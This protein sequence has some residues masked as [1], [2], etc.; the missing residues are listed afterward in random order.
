MMLFAAIL[1]CLLVAIGLYYMCFMN[2]I[3][4]CTAGKK[5]ALWGQMLTP[6][7]KIE[8]LRLLSN[9]SMPLF[10]VGWIGFF[11][12]KFMDSYPYQIPNSLY[13]LFFANHIIPPVIAFAVT[14][15]ARKLQ[16]I[17]EKAN[18]ALPL[19]N[20]EILQ[21]VD[22]TAPQANAIAL[23]A[24]KICLL[25]KSSFVFFEVTYSQ[26]RLGDLPNK[27]ELILLSYYFQQK[28][29]GK[30]ICKPV[31]NPNAHILTEID[32]IRI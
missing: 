14:K 26:Y 19:E 9:L 20:M 22:K 32:F 1:F 18:N 28:Y 31:A 15:P 24:N 21:D 7:S 27:D 5:A 13:L 4:C 3:W 10:A 8:K 23:T 17:I 2:S 29:A 30:F 16:R 25:D 6:I 12:L 11:V